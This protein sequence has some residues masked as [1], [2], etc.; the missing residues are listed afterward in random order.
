MVIYWQILNSKAIGKMICRF[1]LTQ[2]KPQ[3]SLSC[4]V[5]VIFLIPT[6]DAF[7]S[8]SCDVTDNL[9][10]QLLAFKSSIRIG[11]CQKLLS[12]DTFCIGTS[13]AW[14]FSSSSINIQI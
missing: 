6:A 9:L 5:P 4:I 14:I 8:P 1:L 13:D 3:S 10:G 12:A 2:R 11:L 7:F